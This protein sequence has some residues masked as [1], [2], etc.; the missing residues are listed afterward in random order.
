MSQFSEVSSSIVEIFVYYCDCLL[1]MKRR[2]LAGSAALIFF[3]IAFV[4]V[5]VAFGT[6]SW[7]VSDYRYV[8]NCTD[9]ICM[10]K[11]KT[12][13][14]ILDLISNTSFSTNY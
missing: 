10:K 1:Q 7:I 11:M 13:L 6:P 4:L 2:S 8:K 14:L 3:V 9:L 5:L 12:F